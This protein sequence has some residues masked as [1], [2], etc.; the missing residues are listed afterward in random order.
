MT[1]GL[2]AGRPAPASRRARFVLYSLLAE[3][4]AAPPS[5]PAAETLLPRVRDQIAASPAARPRQA[6]TES[7][8]RRLRHPADRE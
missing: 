8:G 2:E 5:T 4:A 6:T 1:L 3:T 7:L